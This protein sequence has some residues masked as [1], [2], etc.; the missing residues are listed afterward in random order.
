M[1]YELYLR[2]QTPTAAGATRLREALE[3][4]EDMAGAA[5]T[6]TLRLPSGTLEL[7]LH[8]AAPAFWEAPEDG[9]AHGL[10]LWVPGG[11]NEEL[12]AAACERAFGWA[13]TLALTVYDPQLGRPI[14]ARDQ[15]AVVH[16]IRLLADYLTETGG[17]GGAEAAHIDVEPPRAPL[18]FRTKFYLALAALIGLLALLTRFC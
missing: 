17:L 2:A 18:P 6:F 15:E 3:R 12:A 8:P 13:K 1:R 7:R 9:V 5:P 14:K 4:D 11:A 10:D 16:R